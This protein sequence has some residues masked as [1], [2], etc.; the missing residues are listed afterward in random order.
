MRLTLELANP[1]LVFWRQSFRASSA[2]RFASVVFA[3]AGLMWSRT[4]PSRFSQ[5]LWLTSSRM[6]SIHSSSNA[7][8][9]IL[10]G[11]KIPSSLSLSACRSALLASLLLLRYRYFHFP[12]I[13]LYLA[14]QRPSDRWNT[15]P[16]LNFGVLLWCQGN[17]E[18]PKS[19]K[20]GRAHV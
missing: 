13:S 12:R 8:M 6:S 15:V 14:H 2:V 7:P 17:G 9:V 1:C 20:I 3:M 5:V 18:K 16:S 11:G 4:K 10:E 19:P